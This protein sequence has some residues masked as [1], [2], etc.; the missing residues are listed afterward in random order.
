MHLR[1]AKAFWEVIAPEMK[2]RLA[3]PREEIFLAN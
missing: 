2:R 1:V 3:L